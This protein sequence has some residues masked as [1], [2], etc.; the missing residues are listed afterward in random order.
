M[1]GENNLTTL[2]KNMS[3]ALQ[4]GIYVFL[5]SEDQF[6]KEVSDKAVMIF[7]EVEGITLVIPEEVAKALNDKEQPRWAFIT[8]TVHSDLNAVGF[9]A[10][11]TER[12]AKAGIS[13]NTVSA[14]YHDHLF[15]PWER[16]A[17]T[18]EILHSFGEQH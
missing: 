17:E 10:A 14:Y 12:L 2:L 9:L 8:L 4:E 3:P 18:M 7:K 11:I 16:R 6:P 15:V 5:T 13:V 1:S